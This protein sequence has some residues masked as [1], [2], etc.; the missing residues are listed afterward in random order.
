MDPFRKWTI[1]ARYR[2]SKSSLPI[3]SAEQ[4]KYD[5]ANRTHYTIRIHD[6]TYKRYIFG[7]CFSILSIFVRL[8]DSSRKRKYTAIL[9]ASNENA[10]KMTEVKIIKENRQVMCIRLPT[11]ILY[12]RTQTLQVYVDESRIREFKNRLQFI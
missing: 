8:S 6:D 12:T 7:A 11:H 10:H 4:S 1:I 5:L 3:Y 9:N 2:F